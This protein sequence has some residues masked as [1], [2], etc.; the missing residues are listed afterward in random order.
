MFIHRYKFVPIYLVTSLISLKTS[1]ETL[2]DFN[3]ARPPNDYL[4][5]WAGFD[6][7]AENLDVEIL[8]EW[9]EDKVVLQVIRYRIGAFKGRNSWMAGIYGYPKGMDNL[10]G[11]LQVHGG[12]QYAHSNA[13]L[14]NAKRG[15]ATLSIAW[16]GRISAPSYTVSPQ[17]VKLFWDGQ[18]EDP[19][20]K[21][22]TDWGALDAYHAPS[23]YGKDA[24]PSIPVAEWTLD[25]VKS[26]RNNAWFLVAL[27]GRRGL[28]FL[29]QQPE[30]D[31]SKLGVYGHSMGGKLTILIAGSDSRVKA[32]VPS[33]GGISDRYTDDP[34]HLDTVSDPPSLRKVSS[35][36]MFLSP[37]N[38]F[39]GRINDLETA[40]GELNT[41][42]WRVVCSPH[43]NHQDSAEYEVGTQVWFDHQ[44][45]RDSVV[46]QTPVTELV[47]AKGRMP[48]LR[49]QPD[50]SREIVGVEVYF[51]QQG[52]LQ[53]RGKAKDDMSNT[54]HRFWKF[55]E[56]QKSKT[57]GQWLAEL[58]LFSTDRPLWVFANV[59]YRLAN[60]I[61]G[62]GYYYGTYESDTFVLSSLPHI[63]SSE[64][65]KL[66]GSL[67]S[68]PRTL[69]IEDF[70]GNWKKDWFS[71]QKKGWGIRTN[72]LYEPSWSAPS[73]GARLSME[74]M[75]AEE[76]KMVI[77]IDG[78][79]VEL[80]LLG[81]NLW[82]RFSY[83]PADFKNSAGESL[84]AWSGIR[85][86][87]L[88]RTE[89]LAVPKGNPSKPLHLGALWKGNPPTFRNLRWID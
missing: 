85:E 7:R 27:A 47:L 58:P 63:I 48:Q 16:A 33:C 59:H 9:E 67:V 60:L 17:E 46:P 11:L 49:I 29:E 55:I 32:A 84:P 76:N 74:I 89:K 2:P 8:K 39:H 43:H 45:K 68:S 12:G 57:N 61:T 81:S 4:S 72:K 42:E 38:D 31:G 87:R 36:V 65:L 28:T 64:K 21:R 71:Y 26:P 73:P 13:V 1:A 88:D 5:M 62:A 10:P 78:Y 22:T 30:V 23:R 40:I 34:L 86:L 82:Q 50:S 56:P 70:S 83:S 18:T 15:Y 24:F 25:P 80:N 51:T 35:P 75:S 79:G 44:L 77:W 69:L 37:A 41:K 66:S 53:E 20:Y 3:P 14:T 6:P 19:K 52:I 54:I